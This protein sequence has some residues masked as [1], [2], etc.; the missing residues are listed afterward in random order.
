VPQYSVPRSVRIR[1]S[2]TSCASYH[3]TTDRKKFGC[4]QGILAIIQFDEGN[5]GIGID[6]GLLIDP[7]DTLE[8]TYIVCVLAPGI[9]VQALDFSVG[10]F[11]VLG[12]LQSSELLLG[13]NQVVLGSFRFQGLEPLLECLQIMPEPDGSHLA[14]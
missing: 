8:R 14:G 2:L 7:A 12:F 6:E 13:E 5:F 10:L 9:R 4:H 1:S 11:L 3:G